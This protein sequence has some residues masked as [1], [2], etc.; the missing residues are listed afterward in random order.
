MLQDTRI[1]H[2]ARQEAVFVIADSKRL[3]SWATAE[4]SGADEHA[5]AELFTQRAWGPLI[6]KLSVGGM[7]S[8]VTD[9]RLNVLGLDETRVHPKKS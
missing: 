5:H 2:G 7:C 1:L 4:S 9:E 6:H 8:Q 3:P